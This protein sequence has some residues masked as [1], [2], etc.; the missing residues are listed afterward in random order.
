MTCTRC[1]EMTWLCKP[2]GT[3]SQ[4]DDDGPFGACPALKQTLLHNVGGG[5]RSSSSSA[6]GGPRENALLNGQA[7][8]ALE[9]NRPNPLQCPVTARRHSVRCH[10][11]EGRRSEGHVFEG[12]V[13]HW[14]LRST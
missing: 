3:G 5:L 11:S 8:G 12:D 1:G 6:W 13:T 14:T 4:K 9:E 2:R 7:L 10:V